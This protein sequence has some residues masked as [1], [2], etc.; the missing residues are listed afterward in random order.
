[1]ASVVS[2]LITLALITTVYAVVISVMA[3]AMFLRRTNDAPLAAHVVAFALSWLCGRAAIA[4]F[5]RSIG[6]EI[7]SGSGVELLCLSV[8]ANTWGIVGAH[9][10]LWREQNRRHSGD[11][12]P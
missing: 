7:A 5:S 2:I 11:R 4:I 10:L 6:N 3:I 8:A 9:I 1:M 12:G